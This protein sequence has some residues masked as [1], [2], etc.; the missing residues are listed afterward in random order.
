MTKSLWVHLAVPA[1]LDSYNPAHDCLAFHLTGA[2]LAME[3]FMNSGDVV[4]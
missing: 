3:L 2:P 1:Q 4:Q